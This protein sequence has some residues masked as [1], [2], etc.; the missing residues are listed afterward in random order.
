MPD[1]V[2]IEYARFTI[3]PASV[4][5]D[6][7]LSLGARLF[8]GDLLSL[9]HDKG[10][11]W[12]S[13]EYLTAKLDM[14]ER[15]V[16]RY[17]SVLLDVGYIHIENVKTAT[18]RA[19]K[20][21]CNIT[22]GGSAN[23]GGMGGGVPPIL[24]GGS[25]NS[26]GTYLTN[27]KDKKSIL[28]DSDES[29]KNVLFDVE[30]KR[31]TIPPTLQWCNEYALEKGYEDG[32]AEEFFDHWEARAWMPGPKVRMADWQASMRTWAR[33]AKK[34]AAER[35]SNKGA[36]YPQ[37][38]SPLTD[39]TPAKKTQTQVEAEEAEYLESERARAERVHEHN[40]QTSPLYAEAY[41][42]AVRQSNNNEE[43]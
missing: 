16:E 36:Q 6:K 18:G 22:I 28:R 15:T 31:K 13:N 38:V 3:I 27:I 24:S 10:Y 14:T 25:A 9:G 40:M 33:N 7:R 17:L 39:S 1:D 2:P 34:Y 32:I 5:F 26:V 29:Q 42:E 35:V 23:Y 19:R 12:A 41:R 8:Y 11:S 20:I 43:G 4:R 37:S 30:K 21:Y